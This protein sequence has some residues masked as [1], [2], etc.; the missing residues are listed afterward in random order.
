M[1]A[2]ALELVG[3]ERSFGAVRAL[4]GAGLTVWPG[5]IHAL[6][7]ENGAGKTTLVSIAAGLLR[8]D[9][10]EIRVAGTRREIADPR[11]A[12]A[13]GIALVPQ[14]DLLVPAASVADNLALLDPRSPVFS[15]PGRRRRRVGDVERETGLTLGAPDAA[16]GTLGVGARQRIGI[17]GALL[18]DPAVL[19]LDEPTAVL[20][21]DEAAALFRV[22]EERAS[23]G[24]AVVLI[25]HRLPEVFAA[26]DRLTL[27]SRGRAILESPIAS[28]A[29][30][31]VAALLLGGAEESTRFPAAG[32]GEARPGDALSVDGLLPRGA[33]APPIDLGLAPGE[34]LTLLAIG[35]NGAEEIAGA[36]VGT[37]PRTGR[38]AVGGRPVPPSDV[39]AFR[40]RGGAFV[41]G[42]RLAEGLVPGLSI[43]E[44]LALTAPPGS[45][46]LDRRALERSAAEAIARFGIRSSGPRALAGS[47][48]GGN[49][50]KLLLARELRGGPRALVAVHPT[51]G[52]DVAATAEVHLRLAEAR[53]AGAALLVVSADPDEARSVGGTIRVVYRGV[54]SPPFPHDAPLDLLGRWLSGLA[55]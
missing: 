55:A 50:Q 18:D 12:R 23:R 9:A 45:L 29:P 42:D 25:T 47:L 34:A 10:G 14:H 11:A 33:A 35:G 38:V 15:T 5:E 54:L 27:L 2:P 53:A 36:I 28:V 7:G 8:A 46:L 1:T 3:I 21:P 22:L 24:R 40:A 41:P 32:P 26:A 37:V 16:C 19:I 17:A 30:E 48:S 39:G 31:A 43:A 52:L 4:G 44:N 49:Q 13:A 51:R 6:L 20:T